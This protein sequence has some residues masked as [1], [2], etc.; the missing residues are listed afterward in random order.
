VIATGESQSASRLNTYYNRIQPLHELADAF[1]LT[2]SSGTIRDDRPEPLIRV[3]SETENRIPRTTPDAANYRQ[4]EVA[5]GS[6]L[7]RMAFDSFQAPI[8]RDL[9]SSSRLRARA[10]RSPACSGRFVVNSAY[11]HLVRW[12]ERRPGT[13]VAPRG[14]YDPAADP[15]ATDKLVRDELGSPR[16]ASG[17]PR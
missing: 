5:G 6:H 15:A 11:R 9:A 4:W 12:R 13:P 14:E 16:A 17:Y 10:I 1:L 8:E 7:P 2:V 3:L